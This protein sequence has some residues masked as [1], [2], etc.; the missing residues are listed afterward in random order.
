LPS[1]IEAVGENEKLD[2]VGNSEKVDIAN[3][4]ILRDSE[5]FTYIATTS[6]QNYNEAMK[7]DDAD[8]WTAAI[9]EEYQ[10]LINRRV[11]EE[12]DPPKGIRVHDG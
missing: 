1:N 6:P 3:F 2:S 4:A 11:F 5:E 7:S 12:T 10:N 8:G 9:T